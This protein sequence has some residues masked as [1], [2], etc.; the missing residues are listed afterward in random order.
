M[1][2]GEGC[3]TSRM[4]PSAL[5]S[6]VRTWAQGKS[7][8]S[9]SFDVSLTEIECCCRKLCCHSTLELALISKMLVSN[10]FGQVLVFF[11]FNLLL[12]NTFVLNVMKELLNLRDFICFVWNVCFEIPLF[13]LSACTMRFK[14]DT[15]WCKKDIRAIK[16]RLLFSD[17]CAKELRALPS[18]YCNYDH[19][20]WKLINEPI[21]HQ[22]W[23]TLNCKLNV[24]ENDE[25]TYNSYLHTCS[26]IAG[27]SL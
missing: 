3:Q 14:S 2:D 11:C 5:S 24:L 4:Q 21:I 16:T 10:F 23:L 12:K 27:Y 18:D 6:T 25:L 19:V 22:L 13:S 7:A 9:E 1:V 26:F 8:N 15:R 20:W 17:K